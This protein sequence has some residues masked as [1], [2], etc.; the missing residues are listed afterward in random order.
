MGKQVVFAALHLGYSRLGNT[1]DKTKYLIGIMLPFA[2]H[3]TGVTVGRRL[4]VNR[5]SFK[6]RGKSPILG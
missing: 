5:I 1:D 3:L 6:S 4:D 2:E